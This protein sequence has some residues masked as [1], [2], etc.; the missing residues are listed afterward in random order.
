MIILDTNT[1]T[2]FSYGHEKVCKKI[3]SVADDEQLAVT[4][5]SRNE[6]LGGRAQSLLK[7]ADEAELRKAME[8]FRQTEEMLADFLIL[9]VDEGAIRHFGRLRKDKKLKKI[10]RADLLIACVTLAQ[11]ALLVTR[12]E[13]AF[14]LV[15][16]LKFENWVD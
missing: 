10:G 2:H 15:A 9:E 16:G 13:K 6:L 3:E 4:L 1:L 11:D 8:R 7:A 14:K 12:N 5:I